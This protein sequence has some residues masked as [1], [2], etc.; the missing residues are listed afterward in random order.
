[1]PISLREMLDRYDESMR[2]EQGPLT[3]A[4]RVVSEAV[5]AALPA[6]LSPRNRPPK[7]R[8]LEEEDVEAELEILGEEEA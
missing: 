3:R 5:D 6:G 1:M 4:K 2:A 8:K 7:R